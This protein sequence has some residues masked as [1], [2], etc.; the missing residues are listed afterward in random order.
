MSAAYSRTSIRHITDTTDVIN[1][2]PKIQDA[3]THW[4]GKL[5]I[6][7]ADLHVTPAHTTIDIGTIVSELVTN[8]SRPEKLVLAVNCAP[9]DKDKTNGKKGNHRKEFVCAELK[10]GTVI[11]GTLNGYELSYVR[12]QIKSLYRLTN[13]NHTSSQFRS[14]EV[15]PEET[16]RFSQPET[17]AQ[18]MADDKLEPM[19]IASSVPAP[20][21]VTHVFRVDNFGNVGLYL[22]QADRARLEKAEGKS[23]KIAFAR[24]SLEIGGRQSQRFFPSFRAVVRQTFFDD[25]KHKNVLTLNSS[26]T[27]IDGGSV[28]MVL[29]LRDLPA[30]TRPGY[31]LPEVGARVKLQIS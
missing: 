30:A 3:Y 6:R 15:L 24:A 16:L 27:L 31:Q 23:I 26:S 1:A 28:P 7:D 19:D 21:D 5:G 20:P 17:R 8:K 10:D 4:M 11:C 14:L 9:P 25:K 29:N 12:D 22:S 2:V 13:T 18:Q